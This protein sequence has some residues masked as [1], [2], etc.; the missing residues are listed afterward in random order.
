[1]CAR[2]LSEIRPSRPLL[3]QL[4]VADKSTP[5]ESLPSPADLSAYVFR[6]ASW[7]SYPPLQVVAKNLP[8]LVSAP[9][10]PL[11]GTEGGVV[12][13]AGFLAVNDSD[14]DES[15][16]DAGELSDGRPWARACS[17]A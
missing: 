2:V 1:M 10:A 9:P 12:P 11:A 3:R 7:T 15:L 8:P 5:S 17:A 14:A 6:R 13:L 4:H 16:G